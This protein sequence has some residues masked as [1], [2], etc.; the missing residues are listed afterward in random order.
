MDLA[1]VEEGSVCFLYKRSIIIAEDQSP[2]FSGD[3]ED[4]NN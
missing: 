4:K 3:N 1:E 2:A